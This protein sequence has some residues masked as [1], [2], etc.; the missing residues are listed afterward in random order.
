MTTKIDG[1]RVCVVGNGVIRNL[2]ISAPYK[3]A[4][5]EDKIRNIMGEGKTINFLREE[6][7]SGCLLTPA[8]VSKNGS[9]EKAL[10][11]FGYRRLEGTFYVEKYAE[12]GREGFH[13]TGDDI[14]TGDKIEGE[15]SEDGQK[16]ETSREEENTNEQEPTPEQGNVENGNN[17]ENNGDNS[18]GEGDVTSDAKD[19]KVIGESEPGN[20]VNNVE[21]NKNQQHNGKKKNNNK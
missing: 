1:Y 10:D 14:I 6:D 2:G 18:S 20:T 11:F 4:L 7:A 17:E 21:I 12:L 15:E 9:I 3:G 19:E 16:T 5:K 8:D 13:K